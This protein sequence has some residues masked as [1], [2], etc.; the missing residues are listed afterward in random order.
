M[1]GCQLCLIVDVALAMR[2]L[3]EST[4]T[5]AT[6]TTTTTTSFPST[7]SVY[8]KF[9]IVG[10]GGVGGV[11]ADELLK[12]G[13]TVTIL[14]RDDSKVRGLG[15][16]AT[17][18]VVW[19]LLLGWTRRADIYDAFGCCCSMVQLQPELQA[20]K[21]RGAKLFKVAYDDE[22]SL[23]KALSG[24]EVVCVRLC[25]PHEKCVWLC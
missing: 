7:M 9:A 16:Q 3:R 21:T 4:R 24:S 22:E 2:Y 8:T 10:A 14:T 1:C 5:Q 17:A 13:A 23:K 19:R 15:L 20:L 18:I 11:A 6:T 25:F 12:K